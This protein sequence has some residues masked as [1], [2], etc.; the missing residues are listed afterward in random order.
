MPQFT[1]VHYLFMRRIATLQTCIALL[2]AFFLA[3]FEH[4]HSGPEHDHSGLIH[5][6]LYHF[7]GV[8]RSVEDHFGAHFAAF[9]DD[10][11]ED[12]HSLDTFTLE[13]AAA[14]A[15]FI[16]PRGPVVALV[17]SE[18]VQPVEA[19]EQRGHDPPCID[20]SIPRAPPA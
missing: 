19:V 7:H 18:T 5:A 12:A 4:V 14:I 15:P 20:R 3:P 2:A 11:H 13:I 6:H 10:D 8:D 16:L 1:R 9:D 17:L